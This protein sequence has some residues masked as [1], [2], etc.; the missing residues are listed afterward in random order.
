MQPLIC[1]Y[2]T[3]RRHTLTTVNRSTLCSHSW[4]QHILQSCLA[5]AANLMPLSMHPY[6]PSNILETIHHA[7]D[8]LQTLDH[9]ASEADRLCLFSGLLKST[10]RYLSCTKDTFPERS[11]TGPRGKW[12]LVQV[13][14]LF[15]YRCIG[16]TCLALPGLASSVSLGQASTGLHSVCCLSLAICNYSF[17]R[18]P[19]TYVRVHVCVYI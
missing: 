1:T 11:T 18:S 15:T 9:T 4:S 17:W 16:A 19:Y 2:E 10:A 12:R 3:H 13:E 5:S 7:Y 6:H 8:M 14:P